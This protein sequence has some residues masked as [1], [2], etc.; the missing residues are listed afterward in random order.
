MKR[1]MNFVG[2]VVLTFSMVLSGCSSNQSKETAPKTEG[3][4]VNIYCWNTE[5]EGIY[6]AYAADLAENHGVEVNFIVIT[7]DYSAYQTNLDEALAEQKEAIDDDKVDIFLIEA[8]YASKYIKSDYALD[9]INDVGLTQKDMADQYQYTK[10]IVSEGGAI[11][12]VTWQ[13][14]PGLFAYRRSIARDVLGT[15][16]PVKVQEKLRNWDSFDQVAKQMSDAGYRMLSGY[17]DSFRTFSNNMS[18]PWVVNNKIR[19]DLFFI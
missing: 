12:G 13:A 16:D 3:D 17:D 10:D 8:D 11:K 18:A 7:N 1:K 4:I 9:V 19:I 2:M 6:K 14:T 15:D 5:F